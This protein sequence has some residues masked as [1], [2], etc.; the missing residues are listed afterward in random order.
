MGFERW[1]QECTVCRNLGLFK[2]GPFYEYLV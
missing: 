2:E 1:D